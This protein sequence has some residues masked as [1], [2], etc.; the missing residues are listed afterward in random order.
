MGAYISKDPVELKSGVTNFYAYVSNTNVWID[1]FG[2]CGIT[3]AEL[4]Q[5]DPTLLEKY[6]TEYKQNPQWQGINPD[7]DKIFY[8]N[9][10]EVDAI[11]KQKGESGGHHPWGLALGGPTGQKLTPTNETRTSKNPQHSQATGMQRIL[12]N[13]LKQNSYKKE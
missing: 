6:R 2:L 5:N 13:R 10:S 12:I 4:L 1:I 8:R 7:K 11:R 3:I 9:K